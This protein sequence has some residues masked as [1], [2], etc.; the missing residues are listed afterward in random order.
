MLKVYTDDSLFN[1]DDFIFDVECAIAVYGYNYNEFAK[2]VVFTIDHGNLV[3]KSYFIDRF[4]FKLYLDELSTTSKALIC[5]EK[6]GNSKIVNFMEVGSNAGE[7]IGLLD[8]GSFYMSNRERL[9]D[10]LWNV[11]EPVSIDNII[12][13]VKELERIL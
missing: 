4:G 2:K 9:R 8:N 12:Y 1:K 7:L 5:L 13:S 10:F 6:V 3:D 11:S